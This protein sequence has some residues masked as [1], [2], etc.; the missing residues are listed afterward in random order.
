MPLVDIP[1]PP[2]AAARPPH[3]EHRAML[4]L[5]ARLTVA[6]GIALAA[7]EIFWR[8]AGQPPAPSDLVAF[9]RLRTE[10]LNSSN[11]VALIGSSRVESDLDPR[12][13]QADMPDMR[14]FQLGINGQSP[15]PFLEDFA[16]NTGF[17]GII[18]CEFGLA[19]LVAAYPFQDDL[20]YLRFVRRRP[21]LKFARTWMHQNVI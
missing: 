13:L 8:L 15:L 11:A 10:A 9:A 1:D 3:Q 20:G 6:C 4:V 5:A 21:Y 17:R 19:Q 14:F 18:L 2:Y 16:E 12:V 7:C